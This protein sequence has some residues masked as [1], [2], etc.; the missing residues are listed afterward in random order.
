MT[1]YAWMAVGYFVVIAI[2]FALLLCVTTNDG[3]K[4]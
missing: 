3:G 1:T 2:G 4:Q